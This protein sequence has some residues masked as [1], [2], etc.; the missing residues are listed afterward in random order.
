MRPRAP[1]TAPLTSRRPFS[2]STEWTVEVQHGDAVATHAAGH[3][4]ALED[5][6]GGRGCTDRA[7]LAVVA[8]RTVAGR[9][10]LEVVALHDTGEALALAG[11]D[12]VDLLAGLEDVDGE[13]L[14]ERVLGGVIGAQ[15]GEVTARRDA[16]LVE[17]TGERLGR[18]CGGRSGRRRSARRC[19]RR[20]PAVRS[21]VTTFGVIST[22]VT[23]TS[24][25]FSSQTWVMPSLVP[26]R[27]L[28]V[29]DMVMPSVA[30]SS[31][32]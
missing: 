12:D 22:T 30:S 3:A 27:P 1:G 19:S 7:G 5:T 4:H 6:A 9:D 2:R 16:G 18:P 24:L 26:S 31:R 32:A 25:L 23:G 13:L 11:A 28:V 15:L 29:L 10:T 21:C 14:A 17:V 20:P 8:V